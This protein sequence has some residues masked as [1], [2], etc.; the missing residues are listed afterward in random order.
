M[1]EMEVEQEGTLDA[2]VA[3]LMATGV[4]SHT[5]PSGAYPYRVPASSIPKTNVHWF[6]FDCLRIHDNPAFNEAVTTGPGKI[7]KAIFVIDPWFNSNYD[8]RGGI[9]VNV[10]RFLLESLTDLDN[11]LRKKPYCTELK[12]FMGQPTVV[13]PNLIRQWNIAKLTFQVSQVSTEGV[14][15]DETI[16]SICI[17]R[18][19]VVSSHFS[20]TLFNPAHLIELCMGK[21]PTVYK[22][23]RHLMSRAGRPEPPVAE[24][25]PVT[26]KL[27]HQTNPEKSSVA[28][29]DEE[30][31]N[32]E[33]GMSVPSLQ[34]LGF[35]NKEALYTSQWVGGETEAL[36]RLSSFCVRRLAVPD[37][38][39][40]KLMSM[41]A[42]SPYM[43][44]GCLSVRHV[45]YHLRQFATTSNKGQ[46]LYDTFSKG[47]LQREFAFLLGYT[48]PSLDVMVGNK[49]SLQLP[50]DDNMQ[51]LTAFRNG[52]TGY[53]W[54]DAV[55]RQIRQEGWAT[56]AARE[57]IAVFLTR[58]YLW[59]SWVHG[60]EF[61][62]E[63]MLDFE[64]PVSSVCWMQS[65]CSAFLCNRVESY[66]P[67]SMGKQMDPD[68]HYIKTYV[69][70]LMNYP[71][72][73]IHAPWKAPSYIQEETHCII[74]MHYPK[75]II[76]SCVTG[77][78]CCRRVKALMSALKEKFM[79]D[80]QSITG[81]M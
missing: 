73:Y 12:V 68:G 16:R 47:L 18:N 2:I 60:K 48:A 78:L 3:D 66:D 31:G 45:F 28:D 39:T 36:S 4:D 11:R 54:V 51:Y 7:F 62:Q 38:P 74:G 69:P 35:S 26:V 63:F 72:D 67:I 43:R 55:I 49:L 8:Q 46:E 14:Q 21:I 5:N 24:P 56:F 77:E 70:E 6:K 76:D 59:V 17:S 32:D 64:L 71:V 57:A 42:L 29:V 20:H 44:F 15:H 65:S 13:I 79:E 58:G 27:Q 40:N 34:S 53:P 41:D 80:R 75:P 1:T 50:W 81:Q 9:S 37:N 30:M 19:V 33:D 23:F 52:M 10:M 25:D 61:F 22:S